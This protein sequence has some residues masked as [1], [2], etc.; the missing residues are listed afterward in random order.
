MLLLLSEFQTTNQGRYSEEQN[1]FDSTKVQRK[2][3]CGI[4]SDSTL[5]S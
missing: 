4:C 5:V 1:Y 3:Y 2:M